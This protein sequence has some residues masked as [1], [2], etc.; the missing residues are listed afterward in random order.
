LNFANGLPNVTT[1]ILI[2]NIKKV[3]IRLPSSEEWNMLLSKIESKASKKQTDNN[4][5]P[6]DKY[7]NTGKFFNVLENVK[8]N[9]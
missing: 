4:V 7:K 1:I 9:D 8:E 2:E 6:V 5:R 3:E